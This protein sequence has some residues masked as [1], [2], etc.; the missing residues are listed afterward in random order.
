MRLQMRYFKYKNTQKNYNNAF[1]EQ[2]H[3][4]TKDEKLTVRK[5]KSWRNLSI[6]IYSIIFFLCIAIFVY[7]LKVIPYPNNKWLEALV[8]VCKVIGGFV[9]LIISGLLAYGVTYPLWKKADSFNLPVIKKEIFSKACAHLR[10]YYGLQKPYILTKCYDSSDK[11]FK[12][13]DVCIFF[14]K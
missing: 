7:V 14:C 6:A 13:H 2:Y 11:K 3:T 4:L 1:K 8:V 5:E 12:N 9:L 10:D